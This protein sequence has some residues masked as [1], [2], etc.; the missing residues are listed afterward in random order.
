MILN[1][2]DPFNHIYIYLIV[3]VWPLLSLLLTASV[4]ITAHIKYSRS[5]LALIFFRVLDQDP[6]WEQAQTFP[7]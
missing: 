4:V 7:R 3:C 1:C 6:M 5:D 2:E